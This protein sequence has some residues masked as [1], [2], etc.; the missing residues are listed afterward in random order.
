MDSPREFIIL[1]LIASCRLA[2][3][4][5]GQIANS[6]P[7]AQCFLLF[8][9]PAV[10][11]YLGLQVSS[12]VFQYIFLARI[13]SISAAVRHG[14]L[15]LKNSVLVANSAMS[16]DPVTWSDYTIEDRLRTNLS[17]G[18]GK[19]NCHG[20]RTYFVHAIDYLQRIVGDNVGEPR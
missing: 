3:P 5:G 7:P 19:E 17:A 6:S 2:V 18:G 20:Q 12:L 4:T 16:F 9:Y 13:C 11:R 10:H 8:V 14:G 15:G 1:P